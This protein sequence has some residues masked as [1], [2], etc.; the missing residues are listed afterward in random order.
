MLKE[1]GTSLRGLDS[2]AADALATTAPDLPQP[3]LPQTAPEPPPVP[4]AR[5]TPGDLAGAPSGAPSGPPSGPPSGAP[6]D[7]EAGLLE[8]LGRMGPSAEER[9]I[10][11]RLMKRLFKGRAA[12]RRGEP[13]D[14]AD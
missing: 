7:D 6:A 4:A 5:R 12:R 2:A 13:G 9:R 1:I 11:A 3:D 8:I 14:D 10:A